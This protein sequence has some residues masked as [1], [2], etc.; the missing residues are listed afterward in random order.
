MDKLDGRMDKLDGRMDKLD[1]RMDKFD[2]RMNGFEIRMDGFESTLHQVLASTHRTQ[3]LVEEQRSE[4]RIVL[5]GIKS[6]MERQDKTEFETKEL[7]TILFNLRP[8]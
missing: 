7:R 5:D 1:G 4:N 3:A 2:L 6:V 8:T